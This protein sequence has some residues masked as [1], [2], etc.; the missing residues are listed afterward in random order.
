[1]KDSGYTRIVCMDIHAGQIQGFVTMPF[2]N[3]YAI[4]LQLDYLRKVIFDLHLTKLIINIFWYPQMSVVVVNVL[5]ILLND[6]VCHMLS[7]INNEITP[8]LEQY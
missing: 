1:M 3:L 8:N 5:E 7:W 4:K 2:D 6:Y